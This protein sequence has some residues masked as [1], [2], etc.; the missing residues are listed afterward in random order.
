MDARSWMDT[1]KDFS[2]DLSS[3]F[4]SLFSHPDRPYQKASDTL[5]QYLPQAQSYLNP[6]V[7]AGQG[8]IP[9]F[10]SWLK[11]M[12]NPSDFINHIMGN[13]QESPY[14]KYEQEQGMRA[15]QNM[16][17]VGDTAAGGSGS[18][19]LM[20]FAQQNAENIS[21][22]DM[23]QWLQHVLGIN[24]QYGQGQFGLMGQG[25]QAGN[26]LTQLMQNYMNNQAGLSY[27]KEAAGQ[28]RTGNI[29]Q[30]IANLF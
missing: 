14:A 20:Q 26:S 19:P 22:Q 23:D 13:Y 5:S 28:G 3:L 9:D 25:M 2:G 12:Q 16:G 1:K 6:F 24:S 30:S 7:K 21:S 17:S 11:S 10:Q 29:I 27:G 18:T 4:G 15:A 8:A